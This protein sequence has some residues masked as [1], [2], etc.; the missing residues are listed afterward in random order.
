MLLVNKLSLYSLLLEKQLL[1]G[2]S[3]Y[4]KILD[5]WSEIENMHFLASKITRK[6]P[7]L[8]NYLDNFRSFHMCSSIFGTIQKSN[9]ICPVS[10]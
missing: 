5:F 6:S 4:A 7:Q 1:L 9:Q 3:F 10:R 2:I 8:S